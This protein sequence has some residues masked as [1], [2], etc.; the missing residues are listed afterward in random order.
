[1][2]YKV[3][4][5]LAVALVLG[6]SAVTEGHAPDGSQCSIS[7]RVRNN[8]GPPGISPSECRS[9]GCCFDS[10]IPNVIWC[11]KPKSPPPPP[12]P[13]HPEEECW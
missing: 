12:P 11:F 9:K 8:C 3:F 2:E 7:P 5:L 4:C 13:H 10:S 1:M 6:L